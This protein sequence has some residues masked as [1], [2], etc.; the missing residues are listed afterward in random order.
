[1][2]VSLI[3]V[4]TIVFGGLTVLGIITG[5]AHGASGPQDLSPTQVALYRAGHAHA[6]V[7]L[8]LALVLQ[9]ALDHVRLAARAVW[10]GRIVAVG[11]PILV[12]AGFFAVA[13]APGAALVLYAGAACVVYATLLTGVGLLRGLSRSM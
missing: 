8:I 9:L 6:G 7:L 2:G 12:S 5:G 3:L 10:S 11:A 4:P 1:M 13:H